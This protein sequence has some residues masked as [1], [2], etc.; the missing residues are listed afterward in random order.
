MT[1]LHKFCL[2]HMYAIR[3]RVHLQRKIHI[4]SCFRPWHLEYLFKHSPLFVIFCSFLLAWDFCF[5]LLVV[6]LIK[7]DS[8]KLSLQFLISRDLFSWRINIVPSSNRVKFLQIIWV[9][10]CDFFLLNITTGLCF[11]TQGT[12]VWVFPTY[13]RCKAKGEF[14]PH[15]CMFF[16]LCYLTR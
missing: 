11:L 9:H 7:F 6:L 8:Y 15:S 4:C 12:W 2:E 10:L 13:F 1:H 3:I 14:F 16:G 5:D